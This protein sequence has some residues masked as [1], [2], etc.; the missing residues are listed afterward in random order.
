[1]INRVVL[2]GRITKDAETKKTQS[3][4][5]VCSFSV[6]VDRKDGTDFI[7]CVAWRQA[8]DFMGQFVKKGDLIAVDG[9]LQTRTWERDGHK[10][11]A[12]EV[13]AD[14]VRR[15][16]PKNVESAV[17]KEPRLETAENWSQ[18]ITITEE[19]LPF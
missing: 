5:S 16:T 12:T 18:G 2:V 17:K 9:R 8:A 15:L 1:M 6:A 11:K 4:L 3:G 7:D 13:I 19:E 14:S 10:N